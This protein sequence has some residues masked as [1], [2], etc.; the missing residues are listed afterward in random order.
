MN[1]QTYCNNPYFESP[2]LFFV[3]MNMKIITQNKVALGYFIQFCKMIDF[4]K[5][6]SAR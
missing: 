5:P 2:F 6:V 4:A 3:H 1:N